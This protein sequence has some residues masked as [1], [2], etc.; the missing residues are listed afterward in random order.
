MGSYGHCDG[1]SPA[2][3][4]RQKRTAGGTLASTAKH[5]PWL[6]TCSMAQATWAT[7]G[8]PPSMESRGNNEYAVLETSVVT[9]NSLR[10]RI[11]VI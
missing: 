2:L 7:S 4:V 9:Q 3:V 11:A 10:S 1:V 6:Q 8:A 5:S